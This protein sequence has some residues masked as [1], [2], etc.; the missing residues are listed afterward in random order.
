MSSPPERPPERR[1]SRLFGRR[2]SDEQPPA[3]GWHVEPSPDGRGAPTPPAKRPRFSMSR[4]GMLVAVIVALFALNIWIVSTIPDK[5]ARATIDYSG[6][7]GPAT[8]RG[9]LTKNNI[10]SVSYEGDQIEG[11]FRKPITF[12]PDSKSTAQFFVTR[13]PPPPGDPDLYPSLS[14]KNVRVASKPPQD[15]RGFVA[16]ALLSFGPTL[17]FLGLLFF[18]FRRSPMGSGGRPRGL[19]PVAGQALHRDRDPGDVRRRRRDRRGQGRAD[20]D[21]RLPEEPGQVP[22]ARRPDPARRAAE[23]PARHRQDA[24]GPGGGRRGRRAVLLDVRLG[25]RRDDRRRR[26]LAACATCSPRRRPRPRR[27]SSSTSSTPSGA[28]RSKGAG[29]LG[30]GHDEREQTLNQIL[31]EMDGFAPT[32]GVIVLAATNRPEVLDPALLRPGR[33]DRRVAVQPPDQAGRAAI[34]KVHTRSVPL[35]DDVDSRRSRRPRPAW[36]APTW[37][38]WSTRPR[39]WRPGATTR[40]SSAPTSPTRSSGSCS[41]PSAR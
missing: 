15:G 39:C 8:F 18:V 24:A 35:A 22:P 16:N 17:L 20:R 38:T 27:S 37:P 34:L 19:R 7:G 9:E 13:Q 14:A 5:H 26:R 29:E 31:T 40:R 12:P 2:D 6:T 33:F 25:V 10:L 41:A 28:P 11:E 23:R 32:S 21:R 36:S 3:P 1:P 30:G 4:H